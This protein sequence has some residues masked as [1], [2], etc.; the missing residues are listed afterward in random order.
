MILMHPALP[1]HSPSMGWLAR[2][3]TMIAIDDFQIFHRPDY[4]TDRKKDSAS[5][6]CASRL[7][8]ISHMVCVV[9]GAQA[10]ASILVHLVRCL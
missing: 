7:G 9:L 8:D 5:S 2:R 6:F 1:Q 3:L 10:F 4:E